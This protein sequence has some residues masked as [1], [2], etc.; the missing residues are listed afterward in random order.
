MRCSWGLIA[1]Q[2]RSSMARR[3]RCNPVGV[4]L[5]VRDSHP[6]G[7]TLLNRRKMSWLPAEKLLVAGSDYCTLHA[8]R[9]ESSRG[10]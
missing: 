6:V 2:C 4:E 10:A 9:E 1:L 7:V 5:E 3:E 8:P